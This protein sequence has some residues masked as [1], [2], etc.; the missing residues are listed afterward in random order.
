MNKLILCT[1]TLLA[2]I[3]GTPLRAAPF[4]AGSTSSI[5]PGDN[6]LYNLTGTV[7]FGLS[8]D[9]DKAT[10]T[11]VSATTLR[12]LRVSVF[13]AGTNPSNAIT[14]AVRVGGAD[15]ILQCTAGSGTT[16]ASCVAP[17]AVA[18]SNNSRLSIHATAVGSFSTAYVHWSFV[19]E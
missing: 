3:A 11:R 9:G 12:N 14:V 1:A 7:A 5:G 18:V 16:T 19:T 15:S 8:A 17:G 4:I 6:R 10:V 2:A 13:F